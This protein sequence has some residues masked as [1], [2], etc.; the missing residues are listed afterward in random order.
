MVIWAQLIAPGAIIRELT[1]V[2]VI[3][4]RHSRDGTIF[5]V[6][7]TFRNKSDQLSYALSLYHDYHWSIFLII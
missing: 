1:Q 3:M 7:K 5:Y 4:W 2:I 6:S